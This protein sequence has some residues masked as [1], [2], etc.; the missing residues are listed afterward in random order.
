MIADI[1]TTAQAWLNQAVNDEKMEYVELTKRLL[2]GGSAN[3]SADFG[4]NPPSAH[5]AAEKLIK[6]GPKGARERAAA[7]R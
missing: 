5:D 2:P 3:S 6:R 4:G 1:I 7:N